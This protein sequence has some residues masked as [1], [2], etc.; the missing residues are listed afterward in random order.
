[1]SQIV[2]KISN[3]R[4]HSCEFCSDNSA[5]LKTEFNLNKDI[6]LTSYYCFQCFFGVNRH[7]QSY[8]V[9]IYSKFNETNRC[10]DCDSL[11]K[12]KLY[13]INLEKTLYLCDSHLSPSAPMIS[14]E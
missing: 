6:M 7:I 3:E 5:E 13:F 8:P 14:R 9:I 10:N 11:G 1:M 2:N 4:N 12:N